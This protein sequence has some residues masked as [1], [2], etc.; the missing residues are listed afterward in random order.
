MATI[1]A[2]YSGTLYRAYMGPSGSYP[3]TGSATPSRARH[4]D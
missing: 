2:T 3:P 1:T 4:G